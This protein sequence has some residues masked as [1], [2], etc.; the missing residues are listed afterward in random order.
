MK[1]STGG[2]LAL[3][4]MVVLSACV[5]TSCGKSQAK[6]EQEPITAELAAGQVIEIKSFS[7]VS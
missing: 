3:A 7:G 5:L 2:W 1:A 6:E 4:A